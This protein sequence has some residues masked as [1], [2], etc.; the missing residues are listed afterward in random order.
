MFDRIKAKEKSK[1]LLAGRSFLDAIGIWIIMAGL[2]LITAIPSVMFIPYLIT[3]GSSIVVGLTGL[4]SSIGRIFTN[5]SILFLIIFGT[6]SMA[7][8]VFRLLY[9]AGMNR[10]ALRMN[11]GDENVRVI[12]IILAGDRLWKYTQI[13]LW[14]I[15]L[16]FL[17]QLPSIA[18]GGIAVWI[19]VDDLK[20]TGGG[21][22]TVVGV[23]LIFAAVIWSAYISID[24]VLQYYYS[25]LIAEDNRN[26]TAYDCI[27]N[28]GSLIS[29]HKWDLFVTMLS[30]LG[31]D[32]VASTG[33]GNIFVS[34]YKYLTYASI[35]EQLIGKFTAFDRM[36]MKWYHNV[37]INQP[38]KEKEKVEVED[39]GERMI[40]FLSGEFAGTSFPVKPGEDICIGRDPQRANIVVSDRNTTVSGLH[41][42]IRY[43]EHSRTYVVTDYSF[44]GT[45]LNNV[46]LM[47]KK[48][49]Q[50]TKGS[51]LKLADGSML[52][53][54]S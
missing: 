15:L 12:D 14:Q 32:M 38:V 47:P 51:V 52:L 54:L 16:Q 41:C 8:L 36:Q 3:T 23:I 21:A 28:S 18:V 1:T 25:Y 34:P 40:E 6:A 46:R 2:I 50:A 31:W 48:S 13:S 4:Y 27:K 29:G 35:Y 39:R 53:R 5:L 44:N 45:Y 26:M 11:R 43:D 10:S 49:T 7:G 20:T 24:K 33:I 30:F 17:W 9:V 19:I 42:M 22:A 37:P